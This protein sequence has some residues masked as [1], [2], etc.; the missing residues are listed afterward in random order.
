MRGF[1]GIS[2]KWFNKRAAQA[3]VERGFGSN[4]HADDE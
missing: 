1:I 4:A 3:S 2:M